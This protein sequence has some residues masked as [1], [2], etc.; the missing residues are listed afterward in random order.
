M[1]AALAV[2]HAYLANNDYPFVIPCHRVSDIYAASILAV[3]WDDVNLYMT[4]ELFLCYAGVSCV[5][6]VL[7][8]RLTLQVTGAAKYRC[9][10]T[11]IIP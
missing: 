5:N 3:E 9:L 4:I 2:T 7:P 11:P 6:S 8:I 1:D 10:A